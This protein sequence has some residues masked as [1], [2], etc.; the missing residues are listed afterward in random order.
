MN[1]HLWPRV[2]ELFNAALNLPPAQRQPFLDSAC[3]GNQELRKEVT[4]LI[5]EAETDGFMTEPLFDLGVALLAQSEESALVGRTLHT[6]RLTRMIGRGGM[7]EVYLAFDIARNRTVAL[8]VL[9]ETATKD[10]DRVMRFRREAHAASLI[11]HPSVAEV[12]EVGEF[13]NNLFIAMEYVEGTTLRERLKTS[14]FTLGEALKVAE[15]IGAA[16][17]AA[18]EIGIAH[19]DLKPENIMI[20]GDGQIKVLDF[21][22][23]K[24]IKPSTLQTISKNAT[25]PAN[26]LTD[27]DS[28]AFGVVFGTATYMAPEQARGNRTDER[29]DIWSFGVLLY[30]MIVGVPP[31]R[32]QTN[33]DIIA[34]VLTTEPQPIRQSFPSAP[35]DLENLINQTLQ[36]EP[37]DRPRSVEVLTVELVR[38]HQRLQERDTSILSIARPNHISWK[39]TDS[40]WRR[41]T[42]DDREAS[43]QQPANEM[44]RRKLLIGFGGGALA[45]AVIAGA[46]YFAGYHPLATNPLSKVNRAGASTSKDPDAQREYQAGLYIWNKRIVENMPQA[47]AHFQKAID[48]DP[49]FARAYAGLAN[50]YLWEGNPHLTRE[51]RFSHVRAALNRALALDPNLAEAHT[52][53]AYL[54]GGDWKWPEAIREYEKAIQADPDYP[55]AHHWYAE[56]LTALGRDDEAVEHI[57][58]ARELDPLS[59]AILND[60]VMIY[61]NVRRYDEAIIQAEKV[62]GFDARYEA[63]AR[64]LLSRLYAFKGN[65]ER[66]RQEFKR[67]EELSSGKVPDMDYANFYGSIGEKEKALDYLKKLQRS[68]EAQRETYM[69]AALYSALGMREEAF[70]WL[71]AAFENHHPSLPMMA[72][73][74]DFDGLRSD[75]RYRAMLERMNLAEFWRDKLS[76]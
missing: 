73:N 11:R 22:L 38:I 42:F 44:R 36:K 8:K 60:S 57:T 37:N 61:L 63:R 48:T 2:E 46:S 16:L 21:G 34:A 66:A 43:N 28:T 12:Y 24:L 23:A 53:L 67:V 19:R 49:G 13:E 5:A 31:F 32:G 50:A 18:H 72:A 52:T 10:A 75:P 58:K 30:E 3:A 59:Y 4:S 76:K 20:R 9:N 6:Y 39:P 74:P 25:V 51:E 62:I 26:L 40:D 54:E 68:G 1:S 17:S 64:V 33:M 15:Q 45:V 7:G 47:L 14:P 65:V 29:S 27:N 69:V 71:E 55:Q 35:P 70:K 41:K 56:F